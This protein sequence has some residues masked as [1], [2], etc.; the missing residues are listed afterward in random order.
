MGMVLELKSL[1]QQ[2]VTGRFGFPAIAEK[3]RQYPLVASQGIY[4]IAGQVA[5]IRRKAAVELVAAIIVA[6]LLVNSAP[7]W[8]ITG[9]AGF[10]HLHLPHTSIPL[11][12]GAPFNCG[13]NPAGIS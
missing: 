11:S 7:Q 10:R 9:Q 4:N 12:Y 13:C 5:T 1:P 8:F 6:I 2:V 3:S